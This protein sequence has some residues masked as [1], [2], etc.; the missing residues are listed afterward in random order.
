MAVAASAEGGQAL[1]ATV[2]APPEAGR[3]NEALLRLLARAWHLPRRDLSII[4]GS[5]SRN[6]VVHIAGDPQR[7]VEQ[8]ASK[9]ARLPGG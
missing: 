5:T 7:L 1:K 6:K 2:A 3:A 9:I 8:V 4:V